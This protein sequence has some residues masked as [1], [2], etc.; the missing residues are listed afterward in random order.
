[1]DSESKAGVFPDTRW[2]LVLRAS[3]P[4]CAD[5]S[6]RALEEL[7]RAYWRPVYAVTRREGLSHEDA[8][9][10]TQTF[11]ADLVATS[12]LER[13]SPERGRLR[14]FIQASLRHHLSHW[15][16]RATAAKR[17]GGRA[18]LRLDLFGAGDFYQLIPADQ[19]TPEVLYDRHWTLALMDRA[20]SRLAAEQ[21]SRGHGDLFT[22]LRSAVTAEG[23]ER[24][25]AEFA[26]RHGL[27]E[28]A[29]KMTV[30]RLRGRLRDII[31]AEVRETVSSP[32]EVDDEIRILFSAFSA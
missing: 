20:M 13:V 7:C 11:F 15:R 18:P 24:P 21:A 30:S 27:S 22:S 1:M 31:R 17:G 5:E 23:S 8:E 32:E 14:W 3:A 26:A 4:G 9:D 19:L 2:T 12:S 6:R 29:V 25:Y 28:A 16:G 10:M